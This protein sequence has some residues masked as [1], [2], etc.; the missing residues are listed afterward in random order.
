M[1]HSS[2]YPCLFIAD[3]F[4]CIVY[5]DDLIF[6]SKYE[7]YLHNLAKKICDLG[8]DLEQEEDAAG[9]MRVYL[10]R[11]E[12]TGTL[13]MK[14]PGLINRVINA[15]VLEYVMDKVK[16]TPAGSVT[17]V[18]NE[19]DIPLSSSFNYISV[20]VMHL[21]LYGNTRPAIAFEFN[22]FSRYMVCHNHSQEEALKQTSWY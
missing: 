13:E 21:Y 6:W 15:V 2:I 10:E 19:D 1:L 4:M 18:N 8:V 11:D 20:V 22:C 3:K 12:E 14:Q 9:F 17:L 7:S 16:Y 5:Y